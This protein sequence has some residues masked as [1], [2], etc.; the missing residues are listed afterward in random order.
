MQEDGDLLDLGLLHAHSP[1]LLELLLPHSVKPGLILPFG[2]HVVGVVERLG[3]RGPRPLRGWGGNGQILP[4][5]FGRALLETEGHT[6][7]GSRLLTS[8]SLRPGCPRHG[9]K[10]NKSTCTLKTGIKRQKSLRV[11]LGLSAAH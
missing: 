8:G 10:E 2:R 7:L 3:W 9:G 6:K 11:E 4:L 1:Q 5:S